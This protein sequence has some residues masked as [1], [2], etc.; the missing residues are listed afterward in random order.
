M[1]DLTDEGSFTV[2]HRGDWSLLDK[3][4]DHIIW[5]NCGFH[6]M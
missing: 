4:V 1:D 3:D 5:R 2:G 6:K